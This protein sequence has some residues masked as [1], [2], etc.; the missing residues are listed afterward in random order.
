MFLLGL[1]ACEKKSSTYPSIFRHLLAGLSWQQAMQSSPAVPS[2]QATNSGPFFW[3]LCQM[4]LIYPSFSGST[5][6]PP[7]DRGTAHWQS[8]LKS[9]LNRYLTSCRKYRDSSYF[10]SRRTKGPVATIY[11]PREL[12]TRLPGG[13][14]YYFFREAEQCGTPIIGELF[15]HSTDTSTQNCRGLS[16]NTAHQCPD[17][18]TT[19]VKSFPF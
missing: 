6:E 10:T 4:R 19:Q 7:G 3:I 12:P 11:T 2:P 13:P 1:Y 17:H 8:L 5:S 14:S 18:S 15:C 16:D 9:L